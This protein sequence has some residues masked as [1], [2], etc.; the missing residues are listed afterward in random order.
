MGFFTTDFGLG[1]EYANPKVSQT[2]QPSGGAG[3]TSPALTSRQA[4]SGPL[5]Q[6]A[7]AMSGSTSGGYNWN[8]QQQGKGL[9]GLSDL[10]G[11]GGLGGGLGGIGGGGTVMPS[12]S[13]PEPRTF[14]KGALPPSGS[15]VSGGGEDSAQ[16]Y[17]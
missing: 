15:Y 10:I 4:A 14:P 16:E 6:L 11:G 1:E 2:Y 17:T 7:Q 9:S 12:P 3:A 13:F 8:Q 5:G